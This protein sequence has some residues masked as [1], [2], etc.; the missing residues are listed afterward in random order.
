MIEVTAAIIRNKQGELLI[1]QRPHHKNCSL[2]W[3]FPEGKQEPG[4]SLEECLVRECREELSI[5]IFVDDKFADTI[6]EN[7]VGRIHLTFFNCTIQEGTVTT[8]EHADLKWVKMSGLDDY[9]FCPADKK[10]VNSLLAR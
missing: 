9:E 2:L 6:S 1:C 10:I 8:K 7:S 4:E 3:E 5:G